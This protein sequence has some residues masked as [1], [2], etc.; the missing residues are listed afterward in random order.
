[1]IY[2]VS[3]FL[4]QPIG[5]LNPFRLGQFIERFNSW[6]DGD[7]GVPPFHYGTH[8]ST[9]GFVLNWLVRMVS[10]VLYILFYTEEYR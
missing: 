6:D 9:G 8:Y 10:Y 2:F 1:M 3:P 7:G 5:A 4:F